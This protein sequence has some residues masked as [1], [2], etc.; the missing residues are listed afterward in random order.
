M[1]KLFHGPFAI[2]YKRAVARSVLTSVMLAATSGLAFGQAGQLDPT[3]ANQGIFSD[4]FSGATGIASAVALQ[5]D[6]KIVAA[7][8]TGTTNSTEG[9]GAVVRLNTDGSLD[10]TFGS[11]G[12]VT[13]R[14]GDLDNFTAGLAIQSD[15]KIVIS[16]SSEESGSVL[17]RLNTDGSFDGSFGIA[18]VVR[19]TGTAGPLV[20]VAEGKIVIAESVGMQRFDTNG[21][22]DTTFGTNGTAPLIG[23]GAG[24]LALLSNGKFLVASG[25]S[26]SGTVA[27]YSSNGSL[28]TTFGTSG[29][30]ATLA[31]PGIVVQSNGAIVTAGS[32]VTQTLSTGNA[33]A[34]GLT[35]FN[36]GG[37]IDATFG[38]HGA[39]VTSFPG[40]LVASAFPLAEQTNGDIVAA[41]SASGGGTQPAGSFALARYQTDGQLDT[42]FGTGGLVTTSFGAN[43]NASIAAVVI[44]SDGK[45][46][47]AGSNSLGNFVVARYLAE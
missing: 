31:A 21:Q 46:V 40:F 33:S 15:G 27:R 45:I 18:G 43:T 25:G 23:F 42:T 13:V 6:G 11:G 19:L 37:T 38:A 12:I 3:F 47:V 26:F 2:D 10:S 35:R 22:L 28:D 20:L 7:G 5:S 34:F 17:V 41:G 24:S 39:V 16:G 4:N 14:F 1:N 32:I 44:Q 9:D 36:A 29:Q 8:N 30:E